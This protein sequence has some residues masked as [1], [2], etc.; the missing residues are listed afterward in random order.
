MHRSVNDP[1]SGEAVVAH[2]SVPRGT[3][4]RPLG[5]GSNGFSAALGDEAEA[6]EVSSKD[7]VRNGTASWVRPFPS[8]LRCRDIALRPRR[9][10]QFEQ[11]IRRMHQHRHERPVPGKL[12]LRQLR[13]PGVLRQGDGSV[14]AE[15]RDGDL[16]GRDRGFGRSVP[17]CQR[18]GGD[19]RMHDA[20]QAVVQR[21]VVHG[22][23]GNLHAVNKGRWVAA[24]RL[25]AAVLVE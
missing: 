14:C 9:R 1:A 18:G 3:E 22:D 12:H 20:V 25:E 6:F 24:I 17:E 4:C 15:S 21:I 16:P 2:A 11:R 7:G 13:A 10:V 5:S 19:R 8:R 23:H